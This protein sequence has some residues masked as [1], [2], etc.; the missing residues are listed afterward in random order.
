MKKLNNK[1]LLGFIFSSFFCFFLC[2][3]SI[4]FH[5]CHY[6]RKV[7]Q[8]LLTKL[9]YCCNIFHHHCKLD[10]N[11]D[12]LEWYRQHGNTPFSCSYYRHEHHVRQGTYCI[13]DIFLH[14]YD[15]L[16]FSKF[17]SCL[18]VDR[19]RSP[20]SHKLSFYFFY[21]S[22]S[23]DNKEKKNTKIVSWWTK[24]KKREYKSVKIRV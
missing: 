12:N 16:H 2:N 5:F 17:V 6:N 7:W 1:N 15:P 4:L 18:Q 9:R 19:C 24:Q 8:D 10:Y 14:L 21:W 11:L 23:R 13:A 3:V 22:W 20:L